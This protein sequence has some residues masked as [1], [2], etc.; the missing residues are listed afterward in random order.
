MGSGVRSASGWLVVFWSCG[1]FGCFAPR[2]LF[3]GH[4]EATWLKDEQRMHEDG[5]QVYLD[6]IDML[7]KES[8]AGIGQASFLK[9]SMRHLYSMSESSGSL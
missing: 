4:I 9:A 2:A 8:Q 3:K 6:P 5:C 7:P 1:S